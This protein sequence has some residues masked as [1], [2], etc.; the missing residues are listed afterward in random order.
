[1][2]RKQDKGFTLIELVVVIS[3]LAVLALIAIPSISGFRASAQNRVNESNA[4]LLT[5]VAQ[6]I[7]ADTGEYPA[8][9][10]WNASSGITAIT[11]EDGNVNGKSYLSET[12]EFQGNGSWKYDKTTGVVKVEGKKE[13]ETKNNN[14][15][16]QGSTN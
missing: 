5:N 15:T 4:R 1:M 16:S 13:D 7:K 12:I 3:I 14:G 10:G 9:E 6:M 11:V 8:M 2:K